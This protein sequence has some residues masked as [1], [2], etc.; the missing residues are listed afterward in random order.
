MNPLVTTHYIPLASFK[1]GFMGRKSKFQA[2]E[3]ESYPLAVELN[4][5]VTR[6]SFENGYQGF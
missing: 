4:I 5:A 1:L 2:T 3:S 6:H